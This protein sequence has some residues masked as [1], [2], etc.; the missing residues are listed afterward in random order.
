MSKVL[1]AY[2]RELFLEQL[3]QEKFGQKIGMQ[4]SLVGVRDERNLTE[5]DIDL[6]EESKPG[7]GQVDEN[8]IEEV[9]PPGRED[10]VKALKKQ[11]GIDNHW[12]VSWASY[13]KTH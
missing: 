8:E 7:L 1:K 13:N 4:P 9:A 6:G 3:V 12:A 10:Q 5:D 2:I 11:P